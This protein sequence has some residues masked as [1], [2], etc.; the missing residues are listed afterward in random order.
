MCHCY[1]CFSF[2]FPPVFYFLVFFMFFFSA[3]AEL[4]RTPLD[5]SEAESEIVAGYHT[6]YSGMRFGLFYAVELLN[7]LAISAFSFSM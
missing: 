3:T 7:T 6:E 4:N 1:C 5:I 2:F